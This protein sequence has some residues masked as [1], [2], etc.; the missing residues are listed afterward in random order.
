MIFRNCENLKVNF[1]EK[2]FNLFE[3]NNTKD[4][5]Q[6][7]IL[8]YNKWYINVNSVNINLNKE[9]QNIPCPGNP[10]YQLSIISLQDNKIIIR[11]NEITEQP[12]LQK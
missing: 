11:T 2:E 8:N 3:N 4:G 10:F 6:L 5:K 1:L 7:T 12:D 9:I